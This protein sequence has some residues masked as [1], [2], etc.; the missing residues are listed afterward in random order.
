M[1]SITHLK[2]EEKSV[3]RPDVLLQL[4]HVALIDAAQSV[5]ELDQ[6]VADTTQERLIFKYECTNGMPHM[7]AL[8]DRNSSRYYLAFS[9]IV[10][11][12]SRVWMGSRAAT[13]DRAPSR[14]RPSQS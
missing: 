5:K 12:A 3:R 13:P 9:T 2:L 8:T 14:V 10:R 4:L 6:A 7:T 11:R 1:F